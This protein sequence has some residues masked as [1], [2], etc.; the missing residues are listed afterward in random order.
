MIILVNYVKV[1]IKTSDLLQSVHWYYFTTALALQM[2][3]HA[4]IMQ[5]LLQY[6]EERVTHMTKT[7]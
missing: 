5:K 3:E 2:Y 4:L 1:S 7:K 6:F